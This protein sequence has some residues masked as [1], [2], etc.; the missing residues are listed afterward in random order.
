MDINTAAYAAFRSGKTDYQLT[1]DDRTNL[2]DIWD[3]VVQHRDALGYWASDL[4]NTEGKLEYL[5]DHANQ[6]D[7]I[8]AMLF[9][10]RRT[11]VDAF[12][13]DRSFW[14]SVLQQIVTPMHSSLFP[15][16]LPMEKI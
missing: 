14:R 12:K 16:F 2:Q 9:Y 1:Q 4:S 3:Y 10:L 15:G 5:K 13:E 8:K 7:E 6:L 11:D